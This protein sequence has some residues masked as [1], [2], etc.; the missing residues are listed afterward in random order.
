MSKFYGTVVGSSNT[1]A[2]RLGHLD[3]RCSAQS[4]DGSVITKLWYNGD[5]VLMVDIEVSDSSSVYGSTIFTGTFDEY[6][7]KLKK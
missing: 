4:Y 7:E 2:T 1:N 6:C 5:G 3:I